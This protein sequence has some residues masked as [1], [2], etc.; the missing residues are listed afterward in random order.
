MQSNMKNMG[1]E[2]FDSRLAQMSA[3]RIS[4]LICSTVDL[5]LPKTLDS[6]FVAQMSSIGIYFP[7]N[8]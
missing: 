1:D 3:T 6:F 7:A 5:S 2:R 4:L 8:A